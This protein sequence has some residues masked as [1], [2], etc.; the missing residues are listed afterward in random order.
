LL[1]TAWAFGGAILTTSAARDADD[2]K[3]A[4]KTAVNMAKIVLITSP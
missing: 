3:T 2:R 1:D 4:A